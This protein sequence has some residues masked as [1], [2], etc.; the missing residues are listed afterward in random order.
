MHLFVD[1]WC[2][3]EQYSNVIFLLLLYYCR[4]LWLIFMFQ[5]H[6]S[7]MT[8]INPNI[9]VAWLTFVVINNYCETFHI[10]SNTIL[11][12]LE[13]NSGPELFSDLMVFVFNQGRITPRYNALAINE[14]SLPRTELLAWIQT[15]PEWNIAKLNPSILC[16]TRTLLPFGVRTKLPE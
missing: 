7:Q 5:V 3:D 15:T 11:N 14:C 4:Q 16:C 6:N 10:C 2:D 1:F 8:T 9:I 12:R 13:I